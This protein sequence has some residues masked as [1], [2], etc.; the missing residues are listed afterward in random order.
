MYLLFALLHLL[1]MSEI[2]PLIPFSINRC[3][4][5]SKISSN[6]IL[7]ILSIASQLIPKFRTAKTVARI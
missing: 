7:V 6:S 4:P 1:A 3:M 5:I 2:P